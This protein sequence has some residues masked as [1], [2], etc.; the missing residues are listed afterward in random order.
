MNKNTQHRE[1]V[2]Q[3]HIEHLRVEE[4]GFTGTT[5]LFYLDA[6]KNNNKKKRI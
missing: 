1:H 6:N 4:I 5:T 2:L 3:L